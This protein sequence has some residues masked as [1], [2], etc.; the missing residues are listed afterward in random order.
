MPVPLPALRHRREDLP[1]LAEALLEQSG[2]DDETRAELLGPEGMRRLQ[3][4]PWSGNIRELRNYLESAAA[5]RHAPEPWAPAPATTPS[6]TEGPQQ[7][8]DLDLPFAEAKRRAT[9]DF[10]RRYLVR[11]LERNDFNVSK[12]AKAAKIDRVY[13]H[14]LMRS[15]GVKRKG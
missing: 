3:Q 7:I 4:S 5:L 1:L 8:V 12:A 9:D 14:R 2:I 15:V 13:L 10:T 6:A 11:L